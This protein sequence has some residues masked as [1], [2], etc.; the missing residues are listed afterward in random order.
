[1]SERTWG[2]KSP[3]RHAALTR[4]YGSEGPP[5][6]PAMKGQNGPPCQ[7]RARSFWH[8]YRID[9]MV[10]GSGVASASARAAALARSIA[11]L[12]ASDTARS[13]SMVACW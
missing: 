7:I 8:N 13:R 9:P 11:S 5:R 4:E 10:A 1:M 6:W 2:F 12:M 3:L